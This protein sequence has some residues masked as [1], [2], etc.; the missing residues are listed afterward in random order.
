PVL[1][2]PVGGRPEFVRIGEDFGLESMKPPKTRSVAEYNMRSTH[3]KM[4]STHP[5]SRGVPEVPKT[6]QNTPQR[7]RCKNCPKL[8][9]PNRPWGRFC[10]PKC[11]MEFNRNGAAFGKLRELLPK[12][13][14]KL[15]AR[16][17]KVIDQRIAAIE[18][19]LFRKS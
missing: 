4:R 11:R 12:W 8:F 15:V 1:H 2:Q 18:A 7:R 17:L 14:A 13:I 6:G 9:T 3:F 10:S 16:E 19:E 5:P